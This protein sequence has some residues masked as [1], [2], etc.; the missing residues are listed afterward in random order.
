[1]N[2]YTRIA[3]LLSLFTLFILSAPSPFLAQEVSGGPDEKE[4]RISFEGLFYLGYEHAEKAGVDS[5][6]FVIDRAYFTTK[7]Q[8]LPRLSSR[9]TLDTSQDR[10]GDGR[11]DMEVRIKYA[12]AKYDLGHLKYLRNLA[13]EGG[14]VHMVWLDFEEHINLYRMRDPMFLERSGIF[15]S[16]DFGMTF[17]GSLGRDLPERYQEEVSSAYPG[18]WGSFALGLYN[19]GGY[20]GDERNTNKV[21]QGRLTLRPFPDH[22]PGLQLSGL[23]IYGKGNRS[24]DLESI[25]DWRTFDLFLSYQ[26]AR[27]T[28]TAQAVWGEGNQKGTWTEPVPSF[29]DMGAAT[30]YSGYALFGEGRLGEG[31]RL[32]GGYD[33]FERTPGASDAGFRRYHVGVGYDLGRRNVILL[34]WDRRDWDAEA[35]PTDSRLQAVLQVK[36]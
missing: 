11:G 5:A 1:V 24:E 23:G 28:F 16:A 35:R 36:F 19:G 21:L 33:R 15:N 34:D 27:A 7:V 29:V 14:I 32:V 30:E 25:P 12:Y 6:A 8:V 26:H 10:E 20:H 13:L 31:W 2:I 4:E 9:L 3:F 18:R 22:L 17:T